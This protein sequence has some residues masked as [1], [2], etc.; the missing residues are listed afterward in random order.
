MD[1]IRKNKVADCDPLLKLRGSGRKIWSD[2]HGD[3]Y[4]RR[5]RDDWDEI[6]GLS[7]LTEPD[8]PIE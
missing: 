3:E 6:S 2:E 8:Q 7:P 1:S 4:V 5:L